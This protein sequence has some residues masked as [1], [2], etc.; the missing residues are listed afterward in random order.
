MV[1]AADECQRLLCLLDDELLQ[2]VA[3]D[4]LQGY[5][6]QEIAARQDWSLSTIERCLRLIRKRWERETQ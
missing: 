5:T 2:A 1:I 3:I 4:R 6:N